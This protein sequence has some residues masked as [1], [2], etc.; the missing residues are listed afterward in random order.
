MK[1]ATGKLARWC[2]R[3]SEF[4]F[5]VIHRISVKNGAADQL[6][7][8]P[9]PGMND[10]PF[11]D[12]VLVPVITEEQP[13][14]GK[15]ERNTKTWHSLPCNNGIETIKPAFP[16][17]VKVSDGTVNEKRLNTRDLVTAQMIDTYS[18]EIAIPVG[19]LG[20]VYS[21]DRE[22]VLLRQSKID[23]PLQNAVPASLRARV[24]YM[25]PYP[26]FVGPPGE[27][28]LYNTLQHEFYWP[29]MDNDA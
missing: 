9:P 23:A 8:F 11:G 6:S 15:T 26:V 13:V 3:L 12:N 29:F 21:Y 25:S 17:I 7:H 16:D 5:E 27:R 14:G 24:L 20:S 10:S 28:R 22:G 4:G 19:Q 18:T 2:L 1:H